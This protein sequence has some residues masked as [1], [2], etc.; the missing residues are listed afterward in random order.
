MPGTGQ[1][2]KV[3]FTGFHYLVRDYEIIYHNSAAI[4]NYD[5]SVRGEKKIQKEFAGF[6]PGNFSDT[7]DQATVSPLSATLD[8]IRGITALLEK[9]GYTTTDYLAGDATEAKVKE[10]AGEKSILHL[11]THCIVD[12][13]IPGNSGLIF[14]E[15]GK[16][17]AGG[18]D[19]ILHLDEILNLTVNAD[20]VI[21]SACSTGKG[22]ISPAEGLLS[23]SRGFL[24]AG[25][26]SVVYSMW[27]VPDAF[28]RDLMVSFY[29]EFLSGKSYGGA[30]REAKLQM[31]REPR[32]SLPFVWAGFVIT[33]R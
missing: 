12:E 8:E 9:H 15:M 1:E 13:V 30:L 16:A 3:G 32:S 19:G 2:R 22:K 24:F 20:L 6:A 18:E 14:P 10:T 27:N 28:T 11:A 33:S 26:S 31:I 23:L 21:L 25:A 29:T 4:W 17:P 7:G 5:R